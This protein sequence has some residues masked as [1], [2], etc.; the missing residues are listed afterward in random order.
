MISLKSIVLS[1]GILATA[2]LS[3]TATRFQLH[4]ITQLQDDPSYTFRCDASIETLEASINEAWNS[5]F[6]AQNETTKQEILNNSNGILA[7]NSDLKSFEEE[8]KKK[9]SPND[10]KCEANINRLINNI[11]K[12]KRKGIRACLIADSPDYPDVLLVKKRLFCH[13]ELDNQGNSTY[14]GKDER[15]VATI[16]HEWYHDFW[17]RL[18]DNQNQLEFKIEGQT[19]YDELATLKTDEQ[20]LKFLKK[21]GHTTSQIDDFEGYEE[22]IKKR[23]RYLTGGTSTSRGDKFF[24]SELYAT[25]ADRAFSK[26]VLI[27]QK[28]RKF[29][30]GFISQEHLEKDQL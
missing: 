2:A 1:A 5:G 10:S 14:L 24:G 25:L 13:Y 28:L 11:A 7:R 29:Y 18:V 20:K 15:I 8:E 22:L 16:I 6:I 3:C 19:F 21:I 23:K 12:C 4:S 27:P 26:R 9:C 17:N 30:Q